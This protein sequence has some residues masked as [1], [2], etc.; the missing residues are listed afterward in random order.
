MVLAVNIGNTHIT[1]GVRGEESWQFTARLRT[2]LPCSTDEYA[3]RLLEILEL[4]QTD[5][6]QIDGAILGSVVPS[7]TNSV[8]AAIQKLFPGR[9]Y[10]V[11]PGLKSGLQIGIDDPAQLGAE[12]VCGAV[13]ALELA[14]PPLIVLCA[15]TA[16]SLMAVDRSRKLVGGVITA[17]PQVAVQAL[18]ANAAQ[19]SEVEH[20][21]APD[22]ILGTNTA[23]CLRAGSV[24]GTALMLDGLFQ[25]MEEELGSPASIVATGAL[26]QA[27]LSC[28]RSN[29]RYVPTL[30]LDGMYQIYRRNARL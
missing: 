11:G 3:I 13:A 30:I 10:T 14:P 7:L 4:Y 1:I 2:A 12:L 8:L 25:K 5:R 28:C 27:V 9:I 6:A 16:L 20:G 17:G 24:W 15:D 18:V 26:P 29:I 21:K 22:S 19:L 23:A